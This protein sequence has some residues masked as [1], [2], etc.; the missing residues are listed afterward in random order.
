MLTKATDCEHKSFSG[1]WKIIMNYHQWG[2]R[3]IEYNAELEGNMIT[4]K[5]HADA[6]NVDASALVRKMKQSLQIG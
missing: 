4:C 3:I 1:R 5:L 6:L 2:N